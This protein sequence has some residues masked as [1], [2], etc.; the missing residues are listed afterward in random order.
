MDPDKLGYTEKVSARS[1]TVRLFCTAI[2]IDR[3]NSEAIGATTTP[4]ITTP[5]AGRQKILTKPRR[6][7][8]IFA[9]ALVVSGNI[10]VRAG[11]VPS[12]ILVCGT[13]TAAISGRVNTAAATVR[14]RMGV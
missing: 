9:L 6:S 5:V 10:N 1:V 14:R 12:S 4:P 2:A 3:I 11:T 8:D 7:S 13:P